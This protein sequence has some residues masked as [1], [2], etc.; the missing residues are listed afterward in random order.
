MGT[1]WH[2]WMSPISQQSRGAQ[3]LMQ[4][5]LRLHVHKLLAWMHLASRKARESR[6]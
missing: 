2:L 4:K 1:V 6:L 5:W 3:R